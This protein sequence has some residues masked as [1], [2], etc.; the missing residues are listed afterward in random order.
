M[1]PIQ[2]IILS[3]S[4]HDWT[5]V[6]LR[7]QVWLQEAAWTEAGMPA[8]LADRNAR[9]STAQEARRLQSEPMFN[10]E[11]AL[12][13]QKWCQLAYSRLGQQDGSRRWS[14]DGIAVEQEDHK[15]KL[16]SNSMRVPF[17][18]EDD[19]DWVKGELCSEAGV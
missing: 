3:V 5:H 1:H 6:T 10:F 13:M 9:A 8:Q 17:N 18:D 14:L 4:L 12:V 16:V 11:T 2:I 15:A 7:L 19:E